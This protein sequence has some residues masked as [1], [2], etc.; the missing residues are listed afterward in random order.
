L[1]EHR[2]LPGVDEGVFLRAL[3]KFAQILEVSMQARQ[4]HCHIDIET[5]IQSPAFE[6]QESSLLR[7]WI[8]KL[9][10]GQPEKA[11]AYA[12]EAAFFEAFGVPT[13]VC[14]PGDIAQAH[15]PDEFVEMEQLT[16][17]AIFLDA[18]VQKHMDEPMH[19]G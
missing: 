6:A 2:Y 16:A 8:Q 5:L 19:I 12:T 10:G 14:G 18:L 9:N 4:P 13:V 17:C 11:V 7:A 1:V 15:K 3:K